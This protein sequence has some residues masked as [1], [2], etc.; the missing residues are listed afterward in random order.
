MKNKLLF[1]LPLIVGTVVS[2]GSGS[3]DLEKNAPKYDDKTGT[4]DTFGYSAPTDGWYNEGATKKYTGEDFRTPERY[5][6]YKDAGMSVMMIQ[7]SWPFGGSWDETDDQWKAR[8]NYYDD[9]QHEAEHPLHDINSTKWMMQQ[10][11]KGGNERC[12][13]TDGILYSMSYQEAVKIGDKEYGLINP[14]W[15]SMSETDK[16]SHP[17]HFNTKEDLEAFV[18]R[19]MDIYSDEPGFYGL[20]I[21]DE[22][23]YKMMVS[24]GEIYQAIKAYGKAKGKE[25]YIEANLNPF[26][27][28]GTTDTQAKERYTGDPNFQGTARE[29]Y[30][31]YLDR[32]LDCSKAEKICMDSYPFLV[33]KSLPYTKDGHMIGCK[34]LA[35][36]CRDRGLRF[37][38]VAQT[39]GGKSSDQPK[40]FAPNMDAM[41]WQINCYLG[42]GSNMFGYF[43]YWR[44]ADNKTGQGS[45]WFDDGTSFMTQM[46]KKTELYYSMQTIHKELRNWQNVITNF[47]YQG[48]QVVIQDPITLP[49]Y[50]Y[51]MNIEKE[52]DKFQYVDVENGGF[53]TD[54]GGLFFLSEL[55]DKDD[56]NR[57]MYMVMNAANPTY[58]SYPDYKDYNFNNNY[59]I[60]FDS[61]FN[62]AVVYYRGERRLVKLDNGVYNGKLEAGYADYIIPYVA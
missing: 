61:K 14:E 26:Y 8:W 7:Q 48:S 6:E 15:E 52:N 5:K 21:R 42:F 50:E 55:A 41:Q 54:E 10:S 49:Q 30:S 23:F 38:T 22:P 39:Y 9:P 57:K 47:K 13:I 46:G 53:K 11:Y 36:K 51:L 28:F 37:E 59:T 34:I 16:T 27:D 43:T 40:W 45:E 18:K 1:A 24:F 19:R 60:K 62:A 29:G 12:I 25:Y 58:R 56:S 20:L 17:Y 3:S 2:C 33:N 31:I 4:I 44:K 35:A 32:Y